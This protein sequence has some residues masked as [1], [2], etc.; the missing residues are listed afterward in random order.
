MCDI[1]YHIRKKQRLI[2]VSSAALM[3]FCFKIHR[4]EGNPHKHRVFHVLLLNRLHGGEYIPHN[5][6][7]FHNCLKP[8]SYAIFSVLSQYNSTCL[9]INTRR[10]GVKF[11]VN[12]RMRSYNIFAEVFLH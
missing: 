5:F 8:C 1:T 10:I 12:W 3:L 4:S 11:G 9:F 6:I 7:S 2:Y